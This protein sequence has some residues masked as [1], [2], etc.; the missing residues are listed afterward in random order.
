M[1]LVQL[2]VYQ[3]SLRVWLLTNQV[4]HHET[5]K[6]SLVRSIDSVCI[7]TAAC[8][9]GWI[10]R[11][12]KVFKPFIYRSQLTIIITRHLLEIYDRDWVIH[13]F[14]FRFNEL[15]QLLLVKCKVIAF[16]GSFIS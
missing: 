15:F 3:S 7:S 4:H 14:L 10:Y 8:Q 5:I 2:L 16:Y 13:M 1:M 11:R 12:I 9:A 6:L